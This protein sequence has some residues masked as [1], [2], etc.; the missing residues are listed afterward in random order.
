MEL[1][2]VETG[3]TV[4]QATLCTPA[5]QSSP[6]KHCPVFW[7]LV[8]SVLVY[9]YCHY[10]NEGLIYVLQHHHSLFMK[11]VYSSATYYHMT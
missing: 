4:H 5:L 10:Q 2:I 6:L 11:V 8:Q 3:W 9:V 1:Y 7:S